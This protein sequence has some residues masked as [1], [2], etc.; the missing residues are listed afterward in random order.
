[1]PAIDRRPR[2][3]R[4]D[5]RT[6]PRLPPTPRTTARRMRATTARRRPT[7][8]RVT[9]PATP[10]PTPPAERDATRR[11]GP[12]TRSQTERLRSRLLD[13]RT[14]L[15][16]G[17]GYGAPSIDALARRVGISKPP[18]HH[19]YADKPALFSAVVHR[20]IERMRPPRDVPLIEGPDLEHV[21]Q[22]LAGMMLR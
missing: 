9:H 15:F 7:T 14:E 12:P 19:R 21:L 3:P 17:A 1:H 8:D 6:I 16:F 18:F 22:R 2:M 20:T 13:A 11:G 5:R 10:V 4:R